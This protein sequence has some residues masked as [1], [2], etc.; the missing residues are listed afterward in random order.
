MKIDPIGM[1]PAAA[2]VAQQVFGIGEQ[3]QDN[4]QLKQQEK[5]QDLQ[6]RGQ[7]QMSDYQQKQQMD[8]WNNTNYEAQKAHIE[9]AGLN[10][11]LLYGMSGGGGVTTGAGT[12]TGVSGGDAANSAA[13]QQANT[14]TLGQMALMG[15]QMKLMEAQTEKTKAEAE[16]ISG[17]DTREGT[18]RASSTEFDV[19]LKKMIGLETPAA[20]A[21]AEKDLATIA[22]DK[23]NA[24]YEAW[25]ASG[26][27]GKTTDDPN[28]PIA[29]AMAAGFQK[30][31]ED[32]KA[33]KI[34]NN[35]NEAT[36]IIKQ[37]E[38]RLAEQGISP[39]SPWWT[40]LVTDML[41]KAGIT[42][43]I[44]A[45]QQEVKQTIQQ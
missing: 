39:N 29:K 33:A 36:N 16:K 17:V 10:P 19:Q 23:A 21:D 18:A 27:N 5:L 6:I 2:G 25:V 37:F 12:A 42:N 20:K 24:E 43:I 9:K 38:A 14:A 34:N 31:L 3:R 7:K 45:G 28:S 30:S 15:A 41:E 4:R 26:F 22:R 1:I 35:I 8:M 32:L 11:A 44:G 40:K 13:T